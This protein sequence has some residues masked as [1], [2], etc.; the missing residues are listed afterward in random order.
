MP[1]I[2]IL[3]IK[4]RCVRLC[5]VGSQPNWFFNWFSSVLVGPEN[6]IKCINRNAVQCHRVEDLLL[7]G[8]QYANDNPDST[9]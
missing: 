8:L 9:E 6:L 5:L 7:D 4:D 3:Y 2:L 1:N